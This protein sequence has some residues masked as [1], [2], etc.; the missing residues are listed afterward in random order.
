MRGSGPSCPCCKLELIHHWPV[1]WL[2]SQTEFNQ[3]LELLRKS[4]EVGIKSALHLLP[5]GFSLILNQHQVVLV[6][7][8]CLLEGSLSRNHVEKYDSYCE[9][10]CF[11]GLVLHL[12]MDF[13]THVV[14][15][16]HE[17]L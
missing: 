7:V 3:T 6:L 11:A 9:Y 12:E 4:V 14:N 1:C 13:R 15:C 10:I 16:A 17:S 2:Q 8:C 5:K